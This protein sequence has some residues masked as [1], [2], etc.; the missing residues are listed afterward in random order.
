M[1]DWG[2]R[3]SKGGD[4]THIRIHVKPGFLGCERTSVAGGGGSGEI[5]EEGQIMDVDVEW[6]L[7][8]RKLLCGQECS[9]LFACVSHPFP[10]TF[11]HLDRLT[12]EYEPRQS[13]LLILPAWRC[14]TDR[15]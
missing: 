1:F 13:L 9:D 11:I 5:E 3:D 12:F 14:T 2:S 4:V 7:R 8:E 6:G 15:N 10:P